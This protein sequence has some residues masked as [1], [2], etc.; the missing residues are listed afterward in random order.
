MRA[1]NINRRLVGQYELSEDHHEKLSEVARELSDNLKMQGKSKAGA[2]TYL[3]EWM[4]DNWEIVKVKMEEKDDYAPLIKV[5]PS[6][7]SHYDKTPE[8]LSVDFQNMMKLKSR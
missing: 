2:S 4:L 5:L 8:E 1:R 6:L 3:M 7:C